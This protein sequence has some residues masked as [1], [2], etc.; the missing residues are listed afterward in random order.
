[1]RKNKIFPRSLIGGHCGNILSE[2]ARKNPQI[3]FF[4]FGTYR[5][6]GI[7]PSQWKW[8]PLIP[9]AE[10]DDSCVPKLLSSLTPGWHLAISSRIHLSGGMLG[11]LLLLQG[12]S[13]ALADEVGRVKMEIT[14]FGYPR[15]SSI[16]M[17]NDGKAF[18]CYGVELLSGREWERLLLRM[19]AEN[20][21]HFFD[22]V[23]IRRSLER[24]HSMLRVS[25]PDYSEQSFPV[26]IAVA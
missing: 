18:Q 17:V 19:K 7:N 20:G 15:T 6:D 4:S 25:S 12:K 16:C 24:G 3:E 13:A 14:R 23:H 9:A 21:G 2:I 8:L 1:M 10:I 26:V 5:D 22:A 11:H